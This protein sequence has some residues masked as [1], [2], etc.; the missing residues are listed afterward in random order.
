L[1]LFEGLHEVEKKQIQIIEPDLIM[2]VMGF[3][4]IV[5]Q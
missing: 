1:G 4:P 2:G 5:E 3:N